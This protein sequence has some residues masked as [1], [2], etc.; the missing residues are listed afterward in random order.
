M[1]VMPCSTNRV[2]V[3]QGPS[4]REA[5]DW[6]KGYGG[7]MGRHL[8]RGLVRIAEGVGGRTNA[9]RHLLNGKICSDGRASEH[10]VVTDVHRMGAVS[11]MEGCPVAIAAER[12]AA[13]RAAREKRIQDPIR[14][15]N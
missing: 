13:V 11:A 14:L 10:E 4:T 7:T 3:S 5:L 12:H 8:Y 1:E 2:M 6:N 9:E 15:P